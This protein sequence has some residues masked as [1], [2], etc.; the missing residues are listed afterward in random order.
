MPSS[1]LILIFPAIMAYAAASDLLTMKIANWVP[2]AL[3]AAFFILAVP[4]GM[5]W[6][7]MAQHVLG[8]MAMLVLGFALFAF[9]WIGG[10]DAKLFAATCLWF[11][12]SQI[13]EYI[14]IGGLLGGGL[15]LI[16]L[17]FRWMP[18][19]QAIAGQTWV[20]R[21][22]GRGNGVPY[23]IA[24]AAAAMI[25]FARSPWMSALGG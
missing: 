22:H 2:L 23:G 19:P 9:G 7:T 4:A 21:L 10:G 12:W 1:L 14:V 3:I 25:V 16:V 8:G 15:T 17:S 6:A 20:A 5:D 13:L 11:G 18:L 24:L